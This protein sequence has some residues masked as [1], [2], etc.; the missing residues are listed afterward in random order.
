LVMPV[1]LTVLV[2]EVAVPPAKSWSATNGGAAGPPA[3]MSTPPLPV[4]PLVANA[5]NSQI[6]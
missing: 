2:V 6:E 1:V 3:E 5:W 4:P